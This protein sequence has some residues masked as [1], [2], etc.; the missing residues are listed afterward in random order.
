MW[1]NAANTLR[2]PANVDFSA[3][4]SHR[5]DEHWKI[6]MNG[7]NLA[8]RLNYQSLFSNRATPSTGRMFIGEVKYT[9]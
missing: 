7:Y 9:Y 5:F 2:V 4:I 1:L 3:V 8:N 6:S